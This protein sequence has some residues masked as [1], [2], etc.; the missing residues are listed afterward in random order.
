MLNPEVLRA[1]RA[2]GVVAQS[3][4][5]ALYSN[6]LGLHTYL[7]VRFSNVHLIFLRKL[8]KQLKKCRGHSAARNGQVLSCLEREYNRFANA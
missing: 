3:V 5:P 8:L 6:R 7:T 1:F 4:D 2:S